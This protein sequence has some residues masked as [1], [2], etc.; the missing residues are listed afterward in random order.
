M[1]VPATCA[2]CAHPITTIRITTHDGTVIYTPRCECKHP[3]SIGARPSRE[4]GE[5]VKRPADEEQS[6]ARRYS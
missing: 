6:G 3:A 2:F 1:T 4:R 5:H